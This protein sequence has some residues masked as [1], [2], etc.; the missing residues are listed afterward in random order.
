MKPKDLMEYLLSKRNI[1]KKD[2]G[3]HHGLRQQIVHKRFNAKSVSLETLEMVCDEVGYSV[4][5]VPKTST[6]PKTAIQVTLE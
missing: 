6:P 2:F 5:L 1:L 3:E 4:Y